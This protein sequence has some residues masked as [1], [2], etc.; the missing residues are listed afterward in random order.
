MCQ[1]RADL[2]KLQISQ[3]GSKWHTGNRQLSGMTPCVRRDWS[4]EA[5]PPQSLAGSGAV[6]E[7]ARRKE[8][9]EVGVETQLLLTAAHSRKCIR[10]QVRSNSRVQKTKHGK[11]DRKQELKKKKGKAEKFESE[12]NAAISQGRQPRRTRL[13]CRGGV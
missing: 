8:G 11:R 6:A 2:C 12:R 13:V 9:I 7:S 3:D 4:A 1:Y 10:G 5:A